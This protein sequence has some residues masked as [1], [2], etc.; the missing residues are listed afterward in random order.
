MTTFERAYEVARR[1]MPDSAPDSLQLVALTAHIK[2]ALDE[3]A[4]ESIELVRRLGARLAIEGPGPRRLL[5]DVD[6]Y[7]RAHGVK[8]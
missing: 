1:W 8:P 4:A 3:Q 6:E 2:I 7:L 5:L